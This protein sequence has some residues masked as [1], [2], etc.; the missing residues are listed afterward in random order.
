MGV[1]T[2]QAQQKK[3]LL[4]EDDQSLAEWICDYLRSHDY[5]LTHIAQG[6]LA[7]ETIKSV[8]PDL[9]ILDVLL[10]QKNG[11]DICKEARTFFNKP[12][13]MLTACGD[14]ADEILGLELGASDYISKPVKPRILLAR[15]KAF[16]RQEYQE[17]MVSKTLSFG[18]L[19]L[20]EDTKSV[21][22]QNEPVS[23]TSNE[24]DLLWILAAQAGQVVSR[25]SLVEQVRGIEYDGLDRSVDIRISRLRKKLGDNSTQPFRI[26]TIWAKGYLFA[27]DTWQ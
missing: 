26:K 7:I 10:P 2:L 23:L 14:E 25:E 16:L 5:E 8:Q 24:F 4:V 13:L 1:K 9:I 27:P 18:Q 21:F 15:L 19:K 22:Y 6:N 20:I 12:I 11:F 3:I 17:S